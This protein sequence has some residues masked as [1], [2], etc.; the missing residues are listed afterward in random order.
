MLR[1]KGS[2]LGAGQ[3]ERDRAFATEPDNDMLKQYHMQ[4]KMEIKGNRGP[5]SCVGEKTEHQSQ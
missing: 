2:E 3:G 1:T 4:D 5:V